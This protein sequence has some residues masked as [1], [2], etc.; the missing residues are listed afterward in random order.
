M[1]VFRLFLVVAALILFSFQTSAQVTSDFAV[2]ADGWTSPTALTPP[3]MTYSA[4]GGNP[5][6]YVQGRTAFSVTTGSGTVWLPFYFVAPVKFEGN[7]STYYGGNLRFDASQSSVGSHLVPLAHAILTDISG[8][9]IYYFPTPQFTP[10]AFG[11]W[12]NFDVKLSA[13][14][15]YWKTTN[16]PAGTNATAAQIQSILTNLADVQILGLYSNCNCQGRIDNVTMY[17]PITINTQPPNRTVCNGVT[18]TFPTAASNNPNIGYHWQRLDPTL[19]WIDLTNTGGYTNTTTATLSVNTTGNFGAGSYRCR[20]S[21]TAVDD[22]ITNSVTLTVNPLP[23]APGATG[24]SSCTTAAL[25]LTATGGAAGQYRWYTVPTLGAPIAGQTAATYTTPTL[26]TTTNYYVAINN[27]TC[28]STRTT[29][30]AT[31]NTTPGAPTVTNGSNCIAGTVTL[32]AAG[33]SAGQ[34]RWYT[35][36]SGGTAI[37]GETNSTYVTPALSATTNYYVAINNGFCE[38]PRTMVT[39]TIGGSN[40]T[41][42]PPVIAGSAQSTTIG[43]KVTVNLLPLITDADGNVVITTLKIIGQPASG[44]VATIQNGQTLVIDYAG[45]SFTGSESVTIEVCDSFLVCS[46]GAI[47]VEVVGS[48][49]IYNAVSPNKDGKNDVFFIENIEKLS[50]TKKNNV[51]IFNRW[52]DLVW[53]GADY[54]NTTVVFT[55]LS[56]G[57]SEL[58]S[59]TYYYK[60]E[61]DGNKTAETGYL[62][63]KR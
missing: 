30:V 53:E 62:E 4:T 46:S 19:G 43:G 32:S 8:V 44:A 35:V 28:E 24:A 58:P 27:G 52:G 15:G 47:T 55:G 18:T 56:K 1:V 11:S 25:T 49:K 45:L 12:A 50:D 31:I 60:I 22:A 41:N 20:I 5:N 48:I 59:G 34:Y 63:L 61:F 7:K 54:N 38:S 57:N 3:G 2:D 40:C 10:P 9:A 39:A 51:R 13:T 36:A 6:G 29:V 21:G 37:P 26:S 42:I 14:P 17:P 33:G 23:T 16:D